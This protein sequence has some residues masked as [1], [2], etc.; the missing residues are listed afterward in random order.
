MVISSMGMYAEM[1]KKL[2]HAQ[3]VAKKQQ[4]IRTHP[5]VLMEPFITPVE[6][7]RKKQSKKGKK[8]KRVRRVRR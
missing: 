5:G 3:A 2:G 1:L 4:D 7:I 6:E 8:P